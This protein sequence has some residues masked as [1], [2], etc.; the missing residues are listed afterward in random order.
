MRAIPLRW[1]FLLPVALLIA[2]GSSQGVDGYAIS[3]TLSGLPAGAQLVLANNGADFLTLRANGSFV[4]PK[5]I[6]AK[7]PYNVTI[8]SIAAGESCLLSNASGTAASDVSDISVVCAST[9]S[10]QSSYI[11]GGTVSGLAGGGSLVLLNNGSDA[12]TL[13]ANGRFQFGASVASGNAFAV[14]IKTQPTGQVCSLTNNSGISIVDVGSLAVTCANT[15]ST[16]QQR[17]TVGLTVSGLDAGSALL[18]KN[19]NSDTLNVSANGAYTFALPLLAGSQY[20]VTL[21]SQPVWQSYSLSNPS[22]TVTADVANIAVSCSDRVATVTTLAGSG[23]AGSADGQGASASFNFPAG[24]GLDGSG[25]LIASDY[26]DG[27]IRKIDAGGNVTTYSSLTYVGTGAISQPFGVAVAAD[28]SIYEGCGA[29]NLIYKIIPTGTNSATVTVLAG[30]GATGSADGQGVGASFNSPLGVA[31]DAGSNVYVADTGN[32]LIR[33]IDPS[34]NV[35][36]LAGS[37]TP[38]SA[39]GQGTSASFNSPA[40]IVIDSG[41]NLYVAEAGNGLIRKID[42]SGNVV[43]FAGSGG[44]GSADGQG[45]SAS[46]NAPTGL[47]IDGSGNIYVADSGNN[48]IR[49]IDRNAN[50][51]TLAGSG[52]AGSADG[53]GAA[54]SFNGPTGIALDGSGNVYVTD[55]LNNLIRKLSP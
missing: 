33:K 31:V 40:G 26:G 35:V 4:F 52:T 47:A 5:R 51:V 6:S 45:T 39:N 41:G 29:C 42:P 3:G 14:S 25:N 49:K 34:G 11:V 16:P 17:Y 19:N 32:N 18:L 21:A 2:C 8:K 38:G 54:A 46:F 53:Q 12:I 9:P 36:T 28:G 20:N 1:S 24:L 23:A 30:S 50:V 15:S 48:L 13:S 22:G 7:Q 10:T 27:T 43:T 44:P 55:Q 37:G